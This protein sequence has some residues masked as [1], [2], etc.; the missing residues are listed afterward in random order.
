MEQLV[1]KS[2]GNEIIFTT[3]FLTFDNHPVDLK[4]THDDEIFNVQLV[5][6][7][8][9]SKKLE[10]TTDIGNEK[11]IITLKN[12]TNA[13]G[14]GPIKPFEVA[15]YSQGQ[16]MFCNFWINKPGLDSYHRLVHI[17]FYK[18]GA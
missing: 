13:L 12:F 9:D 4:F 15:S 2:G 6:E 18:T 8:D 7:D 16:K 14:S 17:T 10:M 5:F 3:S 11:L 1:L